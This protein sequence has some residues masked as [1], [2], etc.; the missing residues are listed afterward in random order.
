MA[1]FF[2]KL[3][4]LVLLAAAPALLASTAAFASAEP[5]VTEG[6]DVSACPESFHTFPL[7][8]NAKQ[9]QR[10]DADLPATMVFHAAV[11]DQKLID[12]YQSAYP[13]LQKISTIQGRTLLTA[14]NNNIRVVISPDK[15]GSQVDIMMIETAVYLSKAN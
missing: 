13:G 14:D 1:V 5:G 3:T 7:P 9:C 11:P 6:P 10:F 15:H 4:R 8:A 2:K 12:Q